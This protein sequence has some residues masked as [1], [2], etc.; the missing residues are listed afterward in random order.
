MLGYTLTI[1]IPVVVFGYGIWLAVRMIKNRKKGGSC[2][3][4]C[5]GCPYA[6]NCSSPDDC[7]VKE[8]S[9]HA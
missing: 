8:D 6:G 5:A 2:C 9:K 4:G 1:V 7:R 3:G